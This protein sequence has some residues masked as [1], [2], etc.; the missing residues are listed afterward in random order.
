MHLQYTHMNVEMGNC[1][2]NNNKNKGMSTV[3][4]QVMHRMLE[5]ADAIK[6]PQRQ[7]TI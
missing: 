3:F 6:L 7:L 4:S 1:R 2:G 5:L